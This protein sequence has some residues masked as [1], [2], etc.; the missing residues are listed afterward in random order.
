MERAWERFHEIAIIHCAK[1]R[2]ASWNG[3]KEIAESYL[4]TSAL[5]LTME[6]FLQ[7]KESFLMNSADET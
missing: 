3:R 7:L 1:Q 4:E 6:Q 5:Q 2:A